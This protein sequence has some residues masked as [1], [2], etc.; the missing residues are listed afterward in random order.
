MALE[1]RQRARTVRHIGHRHPDRMGQTLRV[2]CNMTLDARHLFAR[3]MLDD[4]APQ[5]R[6]IVLAR[7]ESSQPTRLIAHDVGH[8][9]AIVKSECL[10]S[11]GK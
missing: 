11:Y 7:I 8:R 3:V 10:S 2:H 1:H 5:R 6:R 9:L 4:D